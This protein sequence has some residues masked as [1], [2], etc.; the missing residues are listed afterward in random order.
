MIYERKQNAFIINY[1]LT[2]VSRRKNKK[3]KIKMKTAKVRL[4]FGP[5]E[6]PFSIHLSRAATVKTFLTGHKAFSINFPKKIAID[7]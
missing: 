1:V 3:K 6:P 7:L 5:F 2:I 4:I